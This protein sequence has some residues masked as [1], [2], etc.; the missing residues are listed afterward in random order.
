MGNII[1]NPPS[2]PG[3]ETDWEDLVDRDTASYYGLNE[4]VL[5]QWTEGNTTIPAIAEGSQ[6]DIEGSIGRF[7]TEEAISGSTA[8]GT[9]YVKFVVVTGV[10][11]P[12]FTTEEPTWHSTK[13][14]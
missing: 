1:P 7:T 12:E 8:D 4:I 10:V 14:G 11:T 2:I 5:T 9:L 6:I 13:G 3:P